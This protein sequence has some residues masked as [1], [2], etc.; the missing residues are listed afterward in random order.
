MYNRNQSLD[1]IFVADLLQ[2]SVLQEWTETMHN[3]EGRGR[4]IP[5]K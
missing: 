4:R 2:V 5:V 1:A 3:A